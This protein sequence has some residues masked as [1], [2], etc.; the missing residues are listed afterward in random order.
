MEPFHWENQLNTT[1]IESLVFKMALSPSILK[2]LKNSM[3]KST[4]KFTQTALG[5]AAHDSSGK[6][7]PFMFKRRFLMIYLSYYIHFT[8]TSIIYK[9]IVF[10]VFGTFNNSYAHHLSWN[11]ILWNCRENGVDDV[12][13]KILYCGM[14]RTDVHFAKNDWGNT[15]YPIVPG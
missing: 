3:A 10:L 5:W 9:Y 11:Y 8:S 13:I 12:T 1:K 4:P 15:V 7:T 6:L 2:S 14:C